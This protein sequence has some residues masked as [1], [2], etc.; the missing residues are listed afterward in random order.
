[1]KS[2]AKNEVTKIHV[3]AHRTTRNKSQRINKNS[4]SQH[5]NE[6]NEPKIHNA[7]RSGRFFRAAKPG[8]TNRS[9]TI[10]SSVDQESMT[11]SVRFE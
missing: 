4:R 1:M 8:K 11:N 9:L 3:P 6:A 10:P 5:F 2:P 7:A